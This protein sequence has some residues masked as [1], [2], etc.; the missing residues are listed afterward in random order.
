VI[1][2][3]LLLAEKPGIYTVAAQAAMKSTG[4]MGSAAT[5]IVAADVQYFHSL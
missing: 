2:T 1:L 3:L 4:G 5:N